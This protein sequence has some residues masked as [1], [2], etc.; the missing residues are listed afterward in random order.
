MIYRCVVEMEMYVEAEDED[1]AHEAAERYAWK[2][3]QNG[4]DHIHARAVT[5]TDKVNG[6]WG[7]TLPWGGDG[8]RTIYEILHGGL[9]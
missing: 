3:A 6:D 4:V 7:T 5:S 8:K 2:E 9:K 1:E